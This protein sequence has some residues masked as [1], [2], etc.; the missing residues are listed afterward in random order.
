MVIVA[1]W[2]RF[3]GGYWVAKRMGVIVRMLMVMVMVVVILWW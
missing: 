2:C 3:D 1:G